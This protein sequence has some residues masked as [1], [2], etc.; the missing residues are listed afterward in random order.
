[1]A[2]EF[3]NIDF[4]FVATDVNPYT[5]W[6]RQSYDKVALIDADLMKYKITVRISKVAAE[7]GLE[8]ARRNLLKYT[9]DWLN[10][11]IFSRFQAKAYLFCFSAPSKQLSRYQFAIEREYKGNR[12]PPSHAYEGIYQDMEDVYRFVK[13]SHPSLRFDD[14]E[15]DD[16]C[17]MLHTEDTFMWSE[18][19]DQKQSPGLHYNMENGKLDMITP[20]EGFRSLMKQMYTGDTSDNFVG[21][22][23]VGK[24]GAEKALAEPNT[25][26]VLYDCIQK[27]MS[28]HGMSDGIDAF[29]ENWMLARMRTK[30]G[31]YFINKYQHAFDTLESLV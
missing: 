8:F 1:M 4:N 9:D 14:L 30:R 19:K 2:N 31:T 16:I 28:V 7:Q 5:E 27:Y 17:C 10:N 6:E 15:A 22:Q 26:K 18:D 23:G 21:I 29:C 25:E 13:D 11:H 12:K 3:N 24:V 20:V